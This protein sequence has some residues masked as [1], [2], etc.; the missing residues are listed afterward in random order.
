MDNTPIFNKPYRY[1]EVERDLIK[2]QTKKLMDVKLI[3]FSNREYIL[4]TIMPIK[5]EIFKN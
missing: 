5:K 1:S 3:E 4:M 2:A